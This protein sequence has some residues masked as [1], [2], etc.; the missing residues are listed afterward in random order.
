MLL[1]GLREHGWIE[2]KSLTIEWR[3]T[4]GNDE[5][6]QARAAE[7]VNAGVEL[8]VA[9]ATA[10]VQAARRATTTLPIV[11]V[12]G[13]PVATGLAQSLARP[14]GNV[15]GI[16]MFY[17]GLDSKVLELAFATLPK[18]KRLGYL[19]N[20]RS[21]RLVMVGKVLAGLAAGRKSE[22]V[23]FGARTP[24]EIETAFATMTRERLDAVLVHVEPFLVGERGRIAKLARE[25]QLPT[26]TYS[27]EY[28]EAGCLASYGP[29]LKFGFHRMASFIDRILKG[30][31]PGDMPIE[32]TTKIEL[33]LNLS[34]ARELGLTIPQ[35]VLVRADR[36][37]D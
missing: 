6:V 21:E 14:G 32:Q 29:D 25:A 35:A 20:P 5:L 36:V 27:G 9:N 11:G 15:T 3:D 10:P 7:L 12:F 13:D 17:D 2:G 37:I 4:D 8:I 30:A 26:F 19:S 1:Q 24:A 31:N 33:V 23:Q 18:A 22:L 28:V 34:T 16:A